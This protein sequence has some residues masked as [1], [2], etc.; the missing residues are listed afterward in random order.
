MLFRSNETKYLFNILPQRVRQEHVLGARFSSVAVSN[1]HMAAT[2]EDGHLY[3]FYGGIIPVLY[4][5]S[6]QPTSLTGVDPV[7]LLRQGWFGGR[8]VAHRPAGGDESGMS[9]RDAAPYADGSF[10]SHMEYREHVGRAR[11]QRLRYWQRQDPVAEE[12]ATEEMGTAAPAASS[13]AH[14][15]PP[16]LSHSELM[17]TLVAAEAAVAVAEARLFQAH[18]AGGGA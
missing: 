2:T 12:T 9:R 6:S 1:S 15:P 3:M 11:I 7:V 18:H 14:I 5:P 8:R 4:R 10:R 13:I 16:M 17:A